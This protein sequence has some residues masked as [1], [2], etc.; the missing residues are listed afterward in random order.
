MNTELIEQ[1]FEDKDLHHRPGSYG[2]LLTYISYPA[3][4]RRMNTTF[5]YQWSCEVT[6]L[7]FQE[8]EI[9]A[10]VRVTAE[11]ITKMQAGGKRISR[12]KEGKV[13]SLGDDTKAA[14]T[15]AFKKAASMF[16][17]GIYLA[18]G[19]DEEAVSGN[20]QPPPRTTARTTGTITE[21]QLKL[22]KKLRTEMG[23]G[24]ERLCD[25]AYELFK[26]KDIMTLN[27]TQAS[28]LINTL[29]RLKEPV[30]SEARPTGSPSQ[31]QSE[32]EIPF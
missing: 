21:A 26:T 8:D 19:D 18:E 24:P 27:K 6:Q 13:I 3:Y 31:S 2:K 16:G 23:L 17:I 4:V 7:E 5:D 28:T 15:A 14:I 25:T 10:L 32:E 9:I 1:P 30:A 11:G 22:L 29:K 20:G 12:N